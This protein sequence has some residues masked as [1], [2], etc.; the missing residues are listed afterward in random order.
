[1]PLKRNKLLQL[2]LQAQAINHQQMLPGDTLQYIKPYK[3]KNIKRGF[4][5]VIQEVHDSGHWFLGD[6]G[7][8]HAIWHIRKIK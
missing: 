1:M 2:Q 3:R 5:F 6:D 8:W 7:N 4:K